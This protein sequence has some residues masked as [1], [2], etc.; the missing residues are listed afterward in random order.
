MDE[1]IQETDI[2][3]SD[4]AE[5]GNELLNALNVVREQMTPEMFNEFITY[6]IN[7]LK[8]NYMRDWQD[9]ETYIQNKLNALN[10]PFPNGTTNKE[11]S[12]TFEINDDDFERVE[13]E[14]LEEI[15]LQWM[16]EEGNNRFSIK[17]IPT[18]AGD[19]KLK[20][21]CYY[22]GWIP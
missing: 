11:Y 9:N 15:G 1:N 13:F 17:G 6:S 19:Y 3:P 16:K 8:N 12:Q 18:V 14:G 5:K 20:M 21:R 22:R 4:K 7:Q 2:Q 10:I